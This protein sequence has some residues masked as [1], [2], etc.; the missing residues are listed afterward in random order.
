MELTLGFKP[1]GDR[2]VYDFKNCNYSDGWA[3]LDTKQDASYYGNWI[4]PSKRLLFSYAE[5]DT[6]LTTCT[7]DEDF[8]TA[9]RE[10]CDWHKE[11][12][13]FIGIDAMCVPEIE[14]EF[15]RMGLGEFLHGRVTEGASQ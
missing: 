9:V 2:Y 7:D 6:V 12:G 1:M 13:Y 8:I 4:N 5:G 3:Q 11:R 15:D 14:A 10:C